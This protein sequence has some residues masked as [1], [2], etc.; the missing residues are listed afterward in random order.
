MTIFVQLNF[1]VISLKSLRSPNGQASLVVVVGVEVVLAMVVVVGVGVV[2]V[3]VVV[4]GLA[5]LLARSN[6]S[7]GG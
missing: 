6:A 4:V 3:M 5:K 7:A 1:R 2:L